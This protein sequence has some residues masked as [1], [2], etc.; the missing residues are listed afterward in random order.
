MAQ[1]LAVEKLG[2]DKARLDDLTV[3]EFEILRLLLEAN[4]NQ[5]IADI[6]NISP[7]TV[8]NSHYIIKRK[9]DVNSD[10]ELTRLAIRMK[11]LNLRDL[12]DEAE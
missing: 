8:S 12:I 11:L 3:R 4:N 1:A 7:K 6:L 2:Q 10:I 9:L 5:Q